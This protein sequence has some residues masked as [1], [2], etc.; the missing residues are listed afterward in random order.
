MI[1]SQ[2]LHK[3][4]NALCAYLFNFL[5]SQSMFTCYSTYTI[6][7]CALQNRCG[8]Y[9]I[10]IFQK[11]KKIKLFKMKE[12]NEIVLRK[13]LFTSIIWQLCLTKAQL[14]YHKGHMEVEYTLHWKLFLTLLIQ[15]KKNLFSKGHFLAKSSIP[16]CFI[17]LK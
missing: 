2:V 5:P 6:R 15:I 16:G 14:S 8:K 4:L 11:K 7:P 12:L 13:R 1:C 3:E 10:T 9:V 17:F